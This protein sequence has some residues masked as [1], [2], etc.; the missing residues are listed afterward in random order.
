MQG[1][2]H[3][4]EQDNT[5]E[6]INGV[7][8]NVENGDKVFDNSGSLNVKLVTP[9]EANDFP[10]KEIQIDGQDQGSREQDDFTLSTVTENIRGIKANGSSIQDFFVQP[11]LS[12]HSTA[13]DENFLE[14]NRPLSAQLQIGEIIPITKDL[15]GGGL[16][17]NPPQR[18]KSPL[19]P[20]CG[21]DNAKAWMWT[22]FPEIRRECMR[23]LQR[24][25]LLKFEAITNHA[26]DS[27]ARKL[28]AD[29]SSRLHIPLGTDDYIVSDYE[30]EF[31]SI[32]ACALALLKDLPIASEDHYEDS[33]KEKG[34]DAQTYE[35]SHSL[36]RIF[37][38]ASLNWSSNGS[39]N[40]DGIH[41]SASISS[42]GSHL[43]SFN[44][45][46]L[47]DSLVSL[48]ALHP[49]VSMGLGKLPG[50]R[51]YSVVCLYA[52][53]FRDLRNR[54][55]PSE[56]DFI[57]S[58]CR[59]KNWDAKGGKSKSFFAK[60]LDDRFIIKEIKKTEFDSFMKFAPDYFHYM[61]QCYEMRNQ[62]CLAK[63]L[64][65]YQVTMR[66]TKNGK[67]TKHDLM[68][69]E[70]LAFGRNPTRQ[71]DLKGA[72]HARFNSSGDGSGDV[73]LDQN[74]V[75]DM[76]ISPLYVSRKAKR[77]LQRA[78][79]NDTAFLNS[80]HVM[81][82][83]L[84]V[85]VDTQRR[86]LVCGIIDYLRQY[87]WD[88]QLE[89]W[90]KSSLV[91]PKNHL[92]TIISPKEYKKRFRKFIDTHFLSVP[93]HWC[94]Q[95]SSN[96]CSLCGVGSDDDSSHS[97]SLELREHHDDSHRTKFQEQ[98]ERD[99]DSFHT[100]SRDHEKQNGFPS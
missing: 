1:Q 20:S 19:S 30:D 95:R 76:N 60:T 13:E 24:G 71:Y 73:L 89:T 92:P 79:W 69:M 80:I 39:M 15:E 99:E 44:R 81:D 70:N 38:L 21:I 63:I 31:S 23:D 7:Q 78:V 4:K 88:K 52:S 91:V 56:L 75:N 14:D 54:C 53:Q 45:L 68:V 12:D 57:A 25:Y 62:T 98:Q 40:S 64:G 49:E 61:N 2:T 34:M 17:L 22:P 28:I 51:K 90:V 55:C 66:Q 85:G 6:K 93:D 29:E 83:S 82:Y 87:T 8:I 86:E 33:R 35:S 32:I 72:L 10:I 59:C 46:D 47:L 37:S 100:K 16:Y 43:S 11:P 96:P 42:E 18:G 3:L 50:K 48:E 94:S 84:L 41:S 5:G 58:L 65:I 74:F 9:I 97:R 27:T 36:M 26:A 77:I 67:E